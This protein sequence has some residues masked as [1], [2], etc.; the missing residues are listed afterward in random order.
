MDWKDK[1]FSLAELFKIA[2]VHKDTSAINFLKHAE[3]I[4]NDVHW[5]RGNANTKT[6][7]DPTGIR[8][9]YLAELAYDWDKDGPTTP[10][11]FMEALEFEIRD[12]PRNR[13]VSEVLGEL[14]RQ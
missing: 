12:H 14:G 13:N 1:T 8:A 6:N 4:P 2:D 9:G 3:I 7:L 10:L 11:E 5:K